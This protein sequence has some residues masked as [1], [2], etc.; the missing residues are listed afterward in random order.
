SRAKGRGGTEERLE[1]FGTELQSQ[2]RAGFLA[3]SE[4]YD[5]RCVVIDGDRE[6]EAVASDVA[7]VARER[8]R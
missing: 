1:D 8:L 7:Q 5:N 2:M 4:E 6:I 3:L